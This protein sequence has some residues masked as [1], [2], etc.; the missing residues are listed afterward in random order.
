MHAGAQSTLLQWFTRF[1]RGAKGCLDTA[2]V[3]RMMAALDFEAD[4][5]YI[6]KLVSLVGDE[7]GR[8][9]SAQVD[10]LFA[11]LGTPTAAP[12]DA[13]STPLVETQPGSPPRSATPPA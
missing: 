13:D 5:E 3:G 6:D 11:L 2:D 4:T 1:D 9:P 7:D 12:P 10:Q 8:I